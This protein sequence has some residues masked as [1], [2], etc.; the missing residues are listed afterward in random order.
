MTI[1]FLNKNTASRKPTKIRKNQGI[2]FVF[3]QRN[4]AHCIS[5]QNNMVRGRAEGATG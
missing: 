3:A 4:A 1:I 2:S 5:G